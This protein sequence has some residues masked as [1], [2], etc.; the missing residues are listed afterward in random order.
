MINFKVK[1]N[2]NTGN[3]NKCRVSIL[4]QY[5][6]FGHGD[7]FRKRNYTTTCTWTIDGELFAVPSSH[8]ERDLKQFS[9][10][11]YSEMIKDCIEKESKISKFVQDKKK[12]Q[13]NLNNPQKLK[14]SKTKPKANIYNNIALLPSI[15]RQ[16]ERINSNRGT[17]KSSIS[18]EKFEYP[19]KDNSKKIGNISF[20]QHSKRQSLPNSNRETRFSKA[21]NNSR[22]TRHQ[23]NL[24][25]VVSVSNERS[26]NVKDHQLM[27]NNSN[28]NHRRAPSLLSQDRVNKRSLIKYGNSSILQAYANKFNSTEGHENL[29]LSI[30]SNKL[31]SIP[32]KIKPDRMRNKYQNIHKVS[33]SMDGH[34]Q[35]YKNLP[36]PMRL[37]QNKNFQ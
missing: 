17:L 30:T 15:E 9:E 5:Q 29:D 20:I 32:I 1:N 36:Y 19:V 22:K 7:S 37:A 10:D 12:I 3:S 31:L 35:S 34:E 33:I 25:E 16:P 27:P 28:K 26:I 13:F 24:S 4:G 18:P 8:F 21:R 11:T 2:M 14:T 23:R 6:I